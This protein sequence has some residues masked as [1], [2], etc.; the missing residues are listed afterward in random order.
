MIKHSFEVKLVKK[1]GVR[2]TVVYEVLHDLCEEKARLNADY[3]DGLFWVRCPR[4][5][6]RRTFP[7]MDITTVDRSLRK[8]RAEGLIVIGHYDENNGTVNW[9]ATT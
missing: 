4:K 3:H 7:Y 6:L 5:F 2:T 8:L 1:L 9:Y